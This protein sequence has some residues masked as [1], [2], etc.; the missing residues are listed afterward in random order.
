MVG[1]LTN[2]KRFSRSKKM[3]AK[4]ARKEEKSAMEWLGYLLAI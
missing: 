4:R 2:S 3:G 1:W